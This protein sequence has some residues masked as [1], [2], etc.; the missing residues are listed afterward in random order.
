MTK[1]R[2]FELADFFYSSNNIEKVPLRL[3]IEMGMAG[4]HLAYNDFIDLMFILNYSNKLQDDLEIFL[5]RDNYDLLNSG[6]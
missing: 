6:D 5:D 4:R 3:S 2:I 1:K